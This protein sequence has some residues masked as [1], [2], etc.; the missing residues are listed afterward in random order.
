MQKN[1]KE[2]IDALTKFMKNRWDRDLKEYVIFRIMDIDGETHKF[3]TTGGRF[4]DDAIQFICDCMSHFTEGWC[5]TDLKWIEYIFREKINKG[6]DLCTN[7]LSGN[8]RFYIHHVKA[9]DLFREDDELE[10][11]LKKS[12]YD[13]VSKAIFEVMDDFIEKEIEF[14]CCPKTGP[15]LIDRIVEL[16]RR[17]KLGKCAV[18]W[19]DPAFVIAKTF[20]KEVILQMTEAEIRRHYELV[21][22][23][24]EYI[25]P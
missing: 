2:W 15:G 6:Y 19:F 8:D 3:V 12:S 23:M 5:A 20:K 18:N 1:C 21:F 16:E 10:K 7:M 4:R 25:V 9:D 11:F 24:D 17:I 14:I 13:S 22:M